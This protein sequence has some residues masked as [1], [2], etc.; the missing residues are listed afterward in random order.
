MTSSALGAPGYTP[1][2]GFVPNAETAIS[3]ARAIL[4]PIYGAGAIKAEEPLTA[5]RH[6]DTWII[7]GTLPCPKDASCVGGTAELQLSAKDGR[8]LSVVHHK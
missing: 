7:E 1:F 3:I 5:H 2:G 8:I 4:I 6:G